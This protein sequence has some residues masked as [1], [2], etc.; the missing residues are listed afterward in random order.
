MRPTVRKARPTVLGA[1]AALAV[2]LPVSVASAASRATPSSASRA[3]APAV[4]LRGDWAPFT[5]CPVDAK[6][7]LGA[8]GVSRFAVCVASSSPVG[9]VKLGNQTLTSGTSNL[10]FGLVGNFAPGFSVV[11]PSGGAV[12]AAPVNVP[13]GLLGLM[14]PSNIPA[15]S[16]ICL[17]LINSPLNTVKASLQP[18]GTPSHFNFNAGLSAGQPIV[19]LPVKI[20]LTNPLLGP[21]CYIGTNKQPIVLHP[22]NAT[23]PN[24]RFESF[25]ANGT[26][27]PNGVM[28]VTFSTGGTQ[29]DN[30]FAVPGASGCSLLGLGIDI[31]FLVNQKEGLP[32]PAG[33]NSLVLK[34]ASAYLAAL[35][36]PTSV[37]PN[38]GKDL[39]KY[40]HSAVL[41]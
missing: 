27:N 23:R 18:A 36:D 7:M 40:W 29:E 4:R 41:P 6:T 21:N 11:S 28:T 37:A 1:L 38:A 9:S 17:Q 31:S 20:H 25:D 2:F 22:K 5:R 39:S 24:V 10:Q 15:I 35:T 8:D 3:S 33:H 30:S 26:P 13:G 14:C 12:V 19:T 32:S 34:K 16:L